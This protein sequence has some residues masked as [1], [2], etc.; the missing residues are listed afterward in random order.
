MSNPPKCSSGLSL[1]DQKLVLPGLVD[2]FVMNLLESQID[3]I[4]TLYSKLR[5]TLAN[6]MIQLL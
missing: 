1:E 6:V 2:K 4:G 5:E 3:D